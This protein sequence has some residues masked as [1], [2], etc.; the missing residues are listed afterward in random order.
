M[1]SSGKEL[2][3]QAEHMQVPQEMGPGVRRSTRPMSAC[4]TRRKRSIIEINVHCLDS[5]DRYKY[6]LVILL[7]T[8]VFLAPQTRR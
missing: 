8:A 6:M 7:E 2:V 3:E 5:Y 1:T 4:H